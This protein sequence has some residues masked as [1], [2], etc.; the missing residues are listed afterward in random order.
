MTRTFDIPEE[1]F[2]RAEA[3]AR[4]RGVTVRRFL[5]DAMVEAVEDVEDYL[6][7]EQAMAEFR[8]GDGK[9]YTLNELEEFIEVESH[10]DGKG[11]KAVSK[12]S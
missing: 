11:H 2:E 8:E 10:T 1:L 12:A 9:T 4:E 6:A 7:A 5:L 3:A